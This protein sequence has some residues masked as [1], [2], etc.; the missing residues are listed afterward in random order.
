ML[1]VIGLTTAVK[2]QE[3]G[4]YDVTIISEIF[5]SD[6]KDVRYTSLWAVSYIQCTLPHQNDNLRAQG[7]HHV[8]HAEGEPKQQ[9][10]RTTTLIVVTVLN[11][12]S[13]LSIR[14]RLT[15]YGT[16]LPREARP[17]DVFYAFAKLISFTTEEMS[18]SIG[19]PM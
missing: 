11:D 1:G 19:C 15:Y 2:I 3:E 5:P 7:A 9:G 16:S 13:Q 14:R 10:W 18:T 6:P 17:K 12:P 4:H 8:S